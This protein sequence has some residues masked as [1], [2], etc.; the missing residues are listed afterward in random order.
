M[1][2]CRMMLLNL[3]SKK[4]PQEV[5]T[6]RLGPDLGQ[7]PAVCS[8]LVLVQDTVCLVS[9]PNCTDFIVTNNKA[10]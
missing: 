10:S 2:T 6:A 4:R 3:Y 1:L 9:T 8:M 7:T 5:V